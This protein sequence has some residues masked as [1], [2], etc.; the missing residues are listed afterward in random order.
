M[1]G[2]P[3]AVPLRPLP[4]SPGDDHDVAVASPRSGSGSSRRG[5]ATHIGT[6]RRRGS[7]SSGASRLGAIRAPRRI[8]RQ[9]DAGAFTTVARVTEPSRAGTLEAGA[10]SILSH[11]RS[12]PRAVV[13]GADAPDTDFMCVV[14]PGRVSRSL[15]PCRLAA[16]DPG[17]FESPASWVRSRRLPAPLPRRSRFA[18]A[19]RPPMGAPYWTIGSVVR[20][21]AV[22]CLRPALRSRP[23]RGP[24]GLRLVRHDRHT[25]PSLPEEGR[26]DRVPTWRIRPA[27]QVRPGRS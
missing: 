12:H 4:A 2:E 21:E 22:Q 27:G 5:A 16:M 26:G 17:G 8:P 6:S 11:P 14:A 3:E 18:S 15:C 24:G 7:W 25:T 19:P 9:H 20:A 23:R 10:S 1:P 13:G